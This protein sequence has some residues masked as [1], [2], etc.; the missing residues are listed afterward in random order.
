[1]GKGWQ[2]STH[3][4]LD[5][6][7]YDWLQDPLFDLKE[8][9]LGRNKFIWGGVRTKVGSWTDLRMQHGWVNTHLSIH[10]FFGVHQMW[11]GEA[12]VFGRLLAMQSLP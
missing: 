2:H 3:C 1:M 11:K 6:T 10:F 7:L 9:V 5:R 12:P 4:N 8:R